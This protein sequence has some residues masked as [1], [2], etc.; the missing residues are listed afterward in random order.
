MGNLIHG[1]CIQEL[2][3]LPK[4]SID[5][6]LTD[7]P[8]NVLG[9]TQD[10]DDKGDTKGFMEWTRTWLELTY[11]CLKPD[12]ACYVFFGQK[13][14][15]DFLNMETR[16]TVKRML[17]WHHPNLAK[18]TRNMY[19]WTYDPIFYLV[20]GKPKFDASFVGSENVDVFNYAKPQ[21]NWGGDLERVHPCSK[22]VG[23]LKKL[24]KPTT[25]DGDTVL[26]CF[27]GGGSTGIA[28][29]KL[30]RNWIGIE[31]EQKY[32][33]VAKKRLSGWRGQNRLSNEEA[34]PIPPT[35]KGAGILGDF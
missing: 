22:P 11:D 19:L 13:F 21:G 5:L 7:P 31:M 9:Q 26:D 4:E 28:C 10:W 6:V 27:F 30:S 16:Y 17:I 15:K 25:H 29:E 23:L 18:P 20:K 2:S 33:D 1:D 32:Y 12:R 3:K 34:S 14:I 24:I 8:Y 35:P